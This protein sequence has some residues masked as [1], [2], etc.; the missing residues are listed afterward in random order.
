[1][2]PLL[3]WRPAQ[4]TAGQ[5]L[6]VDP[7]LVSRLRPHQRE[8]VAFMYECVAGLRPFDGRG[9]PR[10]W[11][12]AVEAH[13][14]VA[15]AWPHRLCLGPGEFCGGV[16]S[17]AGS[18]ASRLLRAPALSTS[19]LSKPHSKPLTRL[20]G[21]ILADDM[22]LGK[23]LQGITL[24]WA[25]LQ[26][27]ERSPSG[28]AQGPGSCSPSGHHGAQPPASDQTPGLPPAAA[29]RVVI[30]CPTSLVANWDAEFAK[31]LPGCVRTL[32][33]LEP[34]REEA[35]A[36]LD[37]FLRGPRPVGA[38]AGAADR[39][40]Q[41]LIASYETFRQHA[42]RFS[43]PGTCDLLVCDEAHRLKNDATLTNRALAGMACTA[44]VLLSGT[45]LQNRLDEF[46]GAWGRA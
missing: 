22:G 26:A 23:T 33:L 11:G 42:H 5:P 4:G 44:R 20:A 10:V 7:A 27:G 32:A 37:S 18:P 39:A 14:L 31:W 25:L 9:E 24:I 2:E 46:F 40:P 29:R 36:G 35:A 34:S 38:A 43:E 3:L 15:G 21:C 45:P 16:R 6:Y 12:W 30:C 17:P 8:G 19:E 28:R 41:V 1:M 13:G